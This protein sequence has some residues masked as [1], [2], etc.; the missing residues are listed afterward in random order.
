MLHR[1]LSYRPELDPTAYVAPGAHVI[2]R[3][4]LLEHASIWFN[5]VLRG[6]INAIEI[7]RYTNIQDL[8][9]VHVTDDDPVRV[10]NHVVVGHSAHLHGCTVEDGALIGIGATVL[11]GAVVGAG[12]MVGAGALVPER[13]RLEPG[14]LYLGVPCK[15]VRPLTQ[16]EQEGIVSAARKYAEVAR[17]HAETGFFDRPQELRQNP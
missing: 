15:K 3:V 6:D 5:A 9:V 1:Y 8:T 4:R 2:G 11:N 17:N 14:H 16:A 7:G 12:S 10:G 13:A